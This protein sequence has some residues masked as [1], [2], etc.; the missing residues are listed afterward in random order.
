MFKLREDLG[1]ARAYK[2]CQQLRPEKRRESLFH[3]P[4]TLRHDVAGVGD[5]DYPVSF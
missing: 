5:R 2:S 3:R 1:D 4:P